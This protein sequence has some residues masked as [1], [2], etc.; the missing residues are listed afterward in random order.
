[1]RNYFRKDAIVPDAPHFVTVEDI[2]LLMGGVGK[3]S[4]YETIAEIKAYQLRRN[5][6]LIFIGSRIP[7]HMI[8]YQI[9]LSMEQIAYILA[10]R[11]D[12]II[13]PPIPLIPS[14]D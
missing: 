6:D 4:A 14:K 13:Y 12:T 5:P 2:M 8:P 3:T 10:E 9:G 11:D 7:T 1:M